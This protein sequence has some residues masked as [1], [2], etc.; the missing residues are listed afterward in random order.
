MVKVIEEVYCP[1]MGKVVDVGYCNELQMIADKAVKP[2]PE[3]AHLTASDFAV[4]KECPK[5]YD[6][7]AE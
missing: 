2:M 5:R 4:C 3:E 1:M 6:L 7:S